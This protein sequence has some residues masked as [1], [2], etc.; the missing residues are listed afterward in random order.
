MTG[1]D[2][3]LRGLC[4]EHGVFF[5]H[6]A[7]ALGM[8]DAALRRGVRSGELVRVRQGTYV[9]GDLWAAADD[10]DRHV[11]LVRGLLRSHGG[12]VAASHHSASL[13]H[14]LDLW[15]VPLGRAHV[16]RLDGGAGRVIADVTHHEGLCLP[17]DLVTHEGLTMTSAVRAAM[18]SATLLDVEHAL[19]LVDSGLRLGRFTQEELV[20]Q[21]A[22][23]TSWPLSLHL[24]LVV[25]LADGRRASVGE[26]RSCHLFWKAGLPAPEL[27]YE[28][29]DGGVLIG[30]TDFAWPA[31][32]LL[33]E[34]DGKV[35]YGRYLRPGEDPGDAVFREKQREDHLRRVTGCASSGSRGRCCTTPC[36]PPRSSGR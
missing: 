9:L 36:A 24:E 18:E 4:S 26:T 25:R 29:Y 6:E 35:K 16:T 3:V 23:M 33:G 22:L 30:I 17:E 5:R 21:A 19:C 15:E 8:T 14:G 32:G 28:V 34:F 27:Q 12:R 2:D 7:V 11:L 13:L 1:F 10:K 20:G 31:L